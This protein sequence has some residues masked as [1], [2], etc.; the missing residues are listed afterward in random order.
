MVYLRAEPAKEGVPKVA[1]CERK[2]LVEEI[3]QKFAHSI[4]RPT[5]VHEQQPF[6]KPELGDGIVAGQYR[7]QTLLAGY[8]NADVSRLYHGHIIGSVSDR[9]CNRILGPLDQLH[10]HSFLQRRHAA[11]DYCLALRCNVQK[12]FYEKTYSMICCSKIRYEKPSLYTFAPAPVSNSA[13]ANGH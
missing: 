4:V 1:Q 9:Q 11:T 6:Q 12:P 5:T 13:P 8:A 3:A 7:L 10:N 2:I